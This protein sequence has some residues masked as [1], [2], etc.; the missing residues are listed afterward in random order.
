MFVARPQIGNSV[1]MEMREKKKTK[2]FLNWFFCGETVT[3][4]LL[5]V[6][7]FHFKISETYE[8]C[9]VFGYCRH[10]WLKNMFLFYQGFI[11]SSLSISLNNLIQFSLLFSSHTFTFGTSTV[12][13]SLSALDDHNLLNNFYPLHKHSYID[14]TAAF[15]GH[16]LHLWRFF[17]D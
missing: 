5:V 17:I 7:W 6:C 8:S 1:F 16:I 13:L 15:P 14:V 2:T 12:F 10:R 3:F 11:Y 9:Y 4:F